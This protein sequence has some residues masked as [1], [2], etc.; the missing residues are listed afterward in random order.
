MPE[1]TFEETWEIKRLAD[2]TID[3]RCISKPSSRR[4][5][6]A[7]YEWRPQGKAHWLPARLEWTEAVEVPYGQGE[8]EVEIKAPGLKLHLRLPAGF[9]PAT[10]KTVDYMHYFAKHF[11]EAPVAEGKVKTRDPTASLT[12]TLW[13]CHADDAEESIGLNSFKYE[14]IGWITRY[15]PT[16]G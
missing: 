2:H 14:T 1:E 11:A 5:W 9:A 10:V 16:F 8:D 12:E 6:T 7:Q 3:E 4:L 15:Q 13:L